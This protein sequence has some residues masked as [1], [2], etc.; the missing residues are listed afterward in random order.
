MGT[1]V[2]YRRESRRVVVLFR[3]RARRWRVRSHSLLC[4]VRRLV[5]DGGRGADGGVAGG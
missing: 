4:V 2:G 1:P 5:A 3:A